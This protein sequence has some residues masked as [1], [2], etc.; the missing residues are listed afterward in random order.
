MEIN[1]GKPYVQATTIPGQPEEVIQ[2]V[3]SGLAGVPGYTM[4]QT[5]PNSLVFTRSFVPQWAFITGLIAGLLTCVGFLILLVKEEETLTVSANRTADGTRLDVNGAASGAMATRLSGLGS[6]LGGQVAAA[7]GFAP[8]NAPAP[9]P[10]P[11]PATSTPPSP[12]AWHP[13][14]TGRHEQRYWDGKAWTDE[15]I[16]QGTPSTD[17]APG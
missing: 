2:K 10:S 12:A 8:P 15:V 11:T 1:A 14:P 6:S 13:D 16:D 5:G 3:A 9:P 17:P 7:P 4:M